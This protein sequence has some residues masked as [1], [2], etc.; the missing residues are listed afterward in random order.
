MIAFKLRRAL[1]NDMPFDSTRKKWNN[2]SGLNSEKVLP[3]K[4]GLSTYECLGV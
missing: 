4:A 3:I 2:G 1:S